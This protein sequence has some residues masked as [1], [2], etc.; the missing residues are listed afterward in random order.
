[1]I[2]TCKNDIFTAKV[3]ASFQRLNKDCI[4]CKFIQIF[5][6]SSSYLGATTFPILKTYLK[7][8]NKSLKRE[9]TRFFAAKF[10]ASFLTLNKDGTTSKFIQILFISSSQPGTTTFPILKTYLRWVNKSLKREKTRFFKACFQL[11]KV[12]T[13]SKLNQVLVSL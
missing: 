11:N 7:W 5:F 4:T 10:D 1:M 6:I 12:G 9:K 13:T 8:V 2:K 3:E